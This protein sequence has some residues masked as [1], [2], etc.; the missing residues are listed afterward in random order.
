MYPHII[1]DSTITVVADKLLMVRSDHKDFAAV[2]DAIRLGQWDTV[3][4]LMTPPV[5][6]VQTWF[7]SRIEIK[8]GIIYRSGK[9]VDNAVVPH[10]LDL[11]AQGFDATPFLQFLDKLLDNP[12]KRSRDQVWRFVSTNNIAVTAEGNLLFYKRVGKDYWDIHTGNSFQYT[13]GSVHDMDRGE[14][15]DDPNSTCSTGLHVCS[16]DYLSNFSGTHTLLVEVDPACIVS[17]PVD[18]A[19]TKV[20]VCELKVLREIDATPITQTTYA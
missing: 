12:S 14:V 1:T 11:I 8:D 19:N 7:G 16:Y 6:K 4:E 10:I 20:R 3:I 5:Q 18:Y 2:K 13:P 15:D 17:V 9:P